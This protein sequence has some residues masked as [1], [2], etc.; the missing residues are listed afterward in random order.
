MRGE[1][2][3]NIQ[4]GQ[5][6]RGGE[7]RRGNDSSN[8][9]ERPSGSTIERRGERPDATT[10][11]PRS[12]GRSDRTDRSY[13]RTDRSTRD[14]TRTVDRDRTDANR[15]DSRTYDRSNGGNRNSGGNRN[16]GGTYD[17]NNRGNN[18]RGNNDRGRDSNWRGGSSRGD[19]RSYGRSDRGRSSYRQPY[20][21]SGRVSRVHP[22]NGGYR[23]YIVGS[24]YP[25]FIPSAYWRYDRFRVGLSIRLGGYYNPLG[26]YDYYD[27]YSD[28]RGY[29]EGTLRG[30]V[31]SVDYR[32]D[33]FVVRNDASGS[34]VTVVMRDRRDDNVRAGDYVELYGDWT[35]SGVF[36]A[37]DVDLLD[38]AR[39]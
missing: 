19:S 8:R 28:N 14:E 33:T 22:Y 11:T 16:N 15:S 35:R 25:F 10:V 13:D 3:G 29:S 34:F 6:S 26:Y 7:A 36:Q 1:G 9:S 2:R 23:V 21:G 31:E 39:R 30:V 12:T 17:R 4:R 32:R 24:P 37:T 18:N 38:D 20:Y 27:G 5:S